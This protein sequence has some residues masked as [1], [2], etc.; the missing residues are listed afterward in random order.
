[1]SLRKICKEWGKRPL[2]ALFFLPEEDKTGIASTKFIVEKDLELREGLEVYVNW[3]G[4][5]TFSKIVA[6]DGKLLTDPNV[7]NETASFRLLK[8]ARSLECVVVLTM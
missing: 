2:K 5:K 3:N 1:M 4:R 8:E 6:L 7:F